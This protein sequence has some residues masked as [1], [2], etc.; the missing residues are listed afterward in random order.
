VPLWQRYQLKVVGI[1]KKNV[2]F[3]VLTAL[4]MKSSLF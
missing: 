2:G 3:E 4:A 1:L